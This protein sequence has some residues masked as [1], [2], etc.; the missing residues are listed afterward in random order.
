[1]TR[2]ALADDCPFF[3]AEVGFSP[4]LNEAMRERFC[5]GDSAG[6]ARLSAVAYMPREEIPADLLPT[7]AERLQRIVEERRVN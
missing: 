3:N 6:C 7:D 1:M 2:C 5:L 4:D